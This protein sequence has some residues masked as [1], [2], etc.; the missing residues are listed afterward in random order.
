MPELTFFALHASRPLGEAVS[1]A[2]GVPLAAHEE[3][4][5]EWG[6]HKARSLVNVR[7][8]DV[9]VL[10]SLH[11]DAAQSANDKLCR[12]LFF[13]GSLRD[14]AAGALT[15]VVPFL[16]Y[17]RKERKTKPRDPVT[18]RYVAALFE[19]VG[20]DR[21]MTVDVHSLAAF[22]NAFRRPTEHLEGRG[23]F[24]E[25]FA[26]RL[27]ADEVI[28]V[29]PDAGG[30]P[31]AEAFRAGLSRALGRPVDLAFVEKHRSGG[32]VSGDLLAG[33]VRGRVALVLDD[34]VSGGTT[35]LRA[36]RAC[37]RAGAVRVEAAA[38]HGVFTP[39]AGAA[40][41]DPAL[42][43]LAVLSAVPPV[44]DD[45]AARRKLVVLDVAPLLAGA[46][47]R[48]HEGGSIVELLE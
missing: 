46:I 12:L 11:G 24:V 18:T 28:V 40:L 21:V 47:R 36:A 43:S 25:H 19:A 29:S 20:V 17:S 6:Q 37:L 4:E 42:T 16:C 33:D 2:L 35:L 41:A 30:V 44:L 15:A 48:A 26:G 22:Q 32:V 1:R 3:R 27:R 14:A 10:H 34:M 5:F 23:L 38:S 7:G 9:F 45:E 8:R 13:L 39:R 31:R